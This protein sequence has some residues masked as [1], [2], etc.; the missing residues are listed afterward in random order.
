MLFLCWSLLGRYE[1]WHL[2]Y[3]LEW[4]HASF[5]SLSLRDTMMAFMTFT[6]DARG[7]VHLSFEER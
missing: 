7:F 4:F 3:G 6:R 2:L 1:R 5:A